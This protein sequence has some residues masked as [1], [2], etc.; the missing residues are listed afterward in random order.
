MNCSKLKS[1]Q[2]ACYIEDL[3]I[4]E[5]LKRRI[6]KQYLQRLKEAGADVFYLHLCWGR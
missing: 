1:K 3:K 6:A 2:R 5:L 4:L